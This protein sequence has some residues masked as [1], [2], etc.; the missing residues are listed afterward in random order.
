MKNSLK[1]EVYLPDDLLEALRRESISKR[2]SMSGLVRSLL[3]ERYT[4]RVNEV[5]RMFEDAR[6]A[7]EKEQG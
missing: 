7:D 3:V 2:T 6:L 5:N 4:N 1:V